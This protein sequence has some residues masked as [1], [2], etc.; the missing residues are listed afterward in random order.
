[1]VVP[2]GMK[3]S[4]GILVLYMLGAPLRALRPGGQMT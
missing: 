1:M 2:G 4:T 3:L